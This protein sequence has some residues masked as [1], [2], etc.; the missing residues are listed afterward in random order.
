MRMQSFVKLKDGTIY[1]SG[2]RLATDLCQHGKWLSEEK[3]LDDCFWVHSRMI[4]NFG[5][6]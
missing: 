1:R 3:C 2:R 5:R 4:D 6:A